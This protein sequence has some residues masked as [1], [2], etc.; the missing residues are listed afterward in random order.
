[1]PV[2]VAPAPRRLAPRSSTRPLRQKAPPSPTRRLVRTP[3]D[4]AAQ[5]RL[6]ATPASGSA[7]PAGKSVP[8]TTKRA[9]TESPARPRAARASLADSTASIVRKAA[10]FDRF[11]PRFAAVRRQA[12]VWESCIPP[13]FRIVLRCCAPEYRQLVYFSLPA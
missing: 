11:A 9:R 12:W 5:A 8:R 13:T 3:A 6:D 10:R 2:H 4:L 7:G 1:M